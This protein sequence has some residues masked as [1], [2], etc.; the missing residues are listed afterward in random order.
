MNEC[1]QII[2]N[3][4]RSVQDVIDR[5]TSHLRKNIILDVLSWCNSLKSMWNKV[6]VH[7]SQSSSS[8]SHAITLCMAWS[9]FEMKLISSKNFEIYARV[10]IRRL[11]VLAARCQV[12]STSRSS[13][14]DV[15]AVWQYLRNA[16]NDQSKTLSS[17][18]HTETHTHTHTHT[19]TRIRYIERRQSCY[20]LGTSQ[21]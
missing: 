19:H 6:W 2:C 3:I 5:T 14:N 12:P 4:S 13:R 18:S 10:L 11:L 17:S 21:G 15:L 16:L 1:R 8:S 9:Q 7:A 20:I